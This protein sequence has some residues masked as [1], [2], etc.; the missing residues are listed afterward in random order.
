LE[1]QTEGIGDRVSPPLSLLAKSEQKSKKAV[2][3][4]REEPRS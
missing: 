3:F 1:H 2:A 4:S